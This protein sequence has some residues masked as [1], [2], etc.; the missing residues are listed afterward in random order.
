ML[1]K[2]VAKGVQQNAYF[3]NSIRPDGKPHS[4]VLLYVGQH[5]FDATHNLESNR[6]GIAMIN[7]ATEE[8]HDHVQEMKAAA[9]EFTEQARAATH[10]A[11]EATR[12]AYHELEEKT[13]EYGRVADQAIHSNPYTS[14]GV[15]FGLG[16]L[17]GVLAANGRGRSSSCC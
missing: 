2:R 15:A 9:Q 6:R 12:A 11:M 4:P 7:E 17:M 10:A 5:A 14:I 1:L 13:R 3:T 8:V 16:M